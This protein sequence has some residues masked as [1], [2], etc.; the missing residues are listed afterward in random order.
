MSQNLTPKETRK[1]QLRQ[2]IRGEILQACAQVLVRKGVQ[3][4]SMDEVADLAGMSKGSLYNYFENREELLWV[5]IDTY[6]EIFLQ[7]CVPALSHSQLPL[8]ERLHLLIDIFYTTLEEQLGLSAV[9]EYFQEQVRELSVKQV[10]MNPSQARTLAYIREFHE[11]FVPFLSFAVSEV[12]VKNLPPLVLSYS[13]VE[14]VVSL[15]AAARAG[16]IDADALSLRQSTLTLFLTQ[17]PS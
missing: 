6:R 5:V 4:L 14:H 1:I 12:S 11:M 8:S 7:A 17:N 15:H 16:L 13:L 3:G 2:Q 9:L 10:E